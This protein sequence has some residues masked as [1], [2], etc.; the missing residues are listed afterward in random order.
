MFEPGKMGYAEIIDQPIGVQTEAH[1]DVNGSKNSSS[2]NSAG[3][4]SIDQ[5]FLD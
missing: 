2:R 1:A 5:S 4:H 3:R